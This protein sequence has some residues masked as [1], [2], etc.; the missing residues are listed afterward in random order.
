[1]KAGMMQ[2]TPTTCHTFQS[3]TN[4]CVCLWS[5][6]DL[7]HSENKHLLWDGIYLVAHDTQYES[8]FHPAQ[9]KTNRNE[10]FTFK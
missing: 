10:D 8:F 7:P 9:K 3:I 5:S 4:M 1:M 6:R 2:L